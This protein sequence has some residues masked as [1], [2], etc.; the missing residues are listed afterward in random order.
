MSILSNWF[1]R[2]STKLILKGALTVLKALMGK[3]GSEVWKV[4]Q[5]EVM[6]AE[7]MNGGKLTGPEKF[8]QVTMAVKARFPEIKDYFTNLVTELAVTYL[9]ES[10]IKR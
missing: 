2:D 6:R 8:K 10:L 9:K 3:M 7:A 4:T 1:K 5:E